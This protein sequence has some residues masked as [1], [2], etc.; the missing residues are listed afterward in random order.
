MHLLRENVDLTVRN[1]SGRETANRFIH[2]DGEESPDS[3]GQGVPA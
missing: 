2:V 3:V 1:E